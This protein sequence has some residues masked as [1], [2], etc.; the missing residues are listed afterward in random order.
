MQIETGV[1]V[2][3][4]LIPARESEAHLGAVVAD[5]LAAAGHRA[6]EYHRHG[7]DVDRV[8]VEVE[9]AGQFETRAQVDA[10]RTGGIAQGSGVG[11]VGEERE[12]PVVPLRAQRNAAVAVGDAHGGGARHKAWH[13]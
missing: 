4:R 13:A 3:R 5:A 2:D 10:A 12:R 1:A 7:G 11:A 9:V 8:A 6:L